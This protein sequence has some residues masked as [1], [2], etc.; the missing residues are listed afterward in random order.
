MKEIPITYC[1]ETFFA[2]LKSS[3]VAIFKGY[4][5]GEECDD[6]VNCFRRRFLHADVI[7]TSGTNY[8]GKN[9][10]FRLDIGDFQQCNARFN[11]VNMT[12]EWNNDHSFLKK[13]ID[14]RDR[15]LCLG[16][17]FSKKESEYRL[18]GSQF[19][20]I[21]KTIF[22]PRGGGFMNMHSDGFNNNGIP[23]FLVSLSKR[24]DSF[25]SGGVYY[26]VNGLFIDAEEALEKGDVYAHLP[27]VE[28]GVSAVDR[29]LPL[30]DGTGYGRF[31]F[32][33]SLEREN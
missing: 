5:S 11:Y 4:F 20:N 22:Y 15:F 18:N 9:D 16:D 26:V 17:W 1:K 14:L 19:V 31:S 30:E 28:H 8:R 29:D 24:G 12:Y 13:I 33:L 7:R 3:G 27:S 32:N 25:H 2:E 6:W 21:P 10:F 23:N